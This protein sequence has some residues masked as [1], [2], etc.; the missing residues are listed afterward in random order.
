MEVTAWETKGQPKG[1]DKS[2]LKR[3]KVVDCTELA[4]DRIQ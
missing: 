4:Q 2:I 1:E 3:C